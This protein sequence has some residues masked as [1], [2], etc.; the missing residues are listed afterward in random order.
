MTYPQVIKKA[1]EW[2]TKKMP[3]V[4]FSFP[5]DDQLFCLFQNS[6]EKF[7]TKTFDDH[8]FVMAPFDYKKEA[9]IIPSA[10]ATPIIITK[11]DV[12][13]HTKEDIEIPNT[14]DGKE[15]HLNLIN[16][17][18]REI[19][20][21]TAIKVV[22]SRKKDVKLTNFNIK[23]LADQ[24][25]TKS[26]NGL[27]YIWFHPETDLWCGT[28]P[29]TLLKLKETS[30]STISLAGTKKIIE[31]E[32]VKWTSK[33]IQEQAIVTDSIFDSLQ[34]ITPVLKVSKPYTHKVGTL[35]HIRTDVSGVIRNKNA[36]VSK[37]ID[38]LHPTPAVCGTPF[39][40]AKQFILKNELYNREFYTGFLGNVKC[41]VVGSNLYV[42]LRSMKIKN[43]IASIFVGGGILEESNPELEWE[44]TQNKLQTMLKVVA[45]ML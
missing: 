44:E 19:E 12:T 39:I 42:N 3:F 25:F 14:T 29:E 30:F 31:N 7:T 36:R 43:N 10:H 41:D 27:R 18:L 17:V 24:I 22:L 28:T 37:F 2:Y 11:P 20:S 4:L 32:E 13:S 16:E 15:T 1:E 26:Y 9:L 38:A 21:G 34:N 45:P 35:A 6:I 5:D 8:G 23:T 40:N 33:E